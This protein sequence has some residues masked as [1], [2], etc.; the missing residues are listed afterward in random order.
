MGSRAGSCVGA[1]GGRIWSSWLRFP[2]PHPPKPLDR[3]CCGREHGHMPEG[4]PRVRLAIKKP[5]W[6]IGATPTLYAAALRRVVYRCRLNKYLQVPARTK[7]H[8][9][10]P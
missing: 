2:H 9:P 5:Y 8:H 3:R 1:S 4:S 7:T 10:P 6:L